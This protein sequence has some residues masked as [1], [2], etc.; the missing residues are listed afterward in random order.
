MHRLVAR[1]LRLFSLCSI[2]TVLGLSNAGSA[3]SLRTALK[4]SG[5][6]SVPLTQFGRV[7]PQSPNVGLV[8]FASRG[9]GTKTVASGSSQALDLA[10]ALNR[11]PLFGNLT[12]GTPPQKV[13]V[14][15]DT[16][17]TTL[18]VAEG[19][20]GFQPEKS[21][22]FHRSHNTEVSLSYGTGS[23]SGSYGEDVVSVAGV[24]V[25]HQSFV[26]AR[27]LSW[28]HDKDGFDGILGLGLG[29]QVAPLHTIQQPGPPKN[30][31]TELL[32]SL[33]AAGL[34]AKDAFSFCFGSGA[35][36][37]AEEAEVRLGGPCSNGAKDD[38]HQIPVVPAS[39]P[40]WE[41]ELDQFH[42]SGNAIFQHK[43][44]A[45]AL[46]D[47]GSYAIVISR[48]TL[49]GHGHHEVPSSFA[50]GTTVC[51][52]SSL[53]TLGFELNGVVFELQPQDYGCDGVRVEDAGPFP[54]VLGMVF[55][56]KH[57]SF[58]DRA[59]RQISIERPQS[60]IPQF[61]WPFGSS[62]SART[63]QTQNVLK[64][65]LSWGTV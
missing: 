47:S 58:F 9:G 33:V 43:S 1:C 50:S 41:V 35:D 37:P 65:K 34:I 44:G 56:K 15:F 13:R 45:T 59:E 48:A 26:G 3:R 57:V 53:P 31:P 51:D 23:A 62:T 27:S 29:R 40:H 18:W 54:M 30:G 17:S 60:M 46:I 2:S 5:I 39:G 4:A 63:N 64:Q 52:R 20:G 14:V 19:P 55:L 38:F 6:L 8:G 16:G 61:T 49:A 32:G 28:S 22:S 12:I 25:P 36:T 21:K 11:A 10:A 24:M 42:W 7:S